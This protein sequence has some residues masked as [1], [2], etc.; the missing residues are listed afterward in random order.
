MNERISARMGASH[1]LVLFPPLRGDVRVAANALRVERSP[2]YT[3][4]R[5]LRGMRTC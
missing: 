2:T 4:Q 5:T 1:L 3:S